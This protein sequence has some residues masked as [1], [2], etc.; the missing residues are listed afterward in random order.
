M[1]KKLFYALLWICVLSSTV[2]TADAPTT[3]ATP[4]PAHVAM[5]R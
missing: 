1:F 2:Y 3:L 4:E 5:P